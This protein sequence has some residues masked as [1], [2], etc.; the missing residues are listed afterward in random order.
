MVE[1][2]TAR[3][4]RREFTPTSPLGPLQRSADVLPSFKALFLFAECGFIVGK[5]RVRRCREQTA[6]H[7]ILS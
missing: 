7:Y 3:V 4:L 5:G 6:N 2:P 1:V